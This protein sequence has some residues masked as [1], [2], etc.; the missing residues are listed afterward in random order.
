MYYA[1]FDDNCTL[2]LNFRHTI[3]FIIASLVSSIRLACDWRRSLE[4]EGHLGSQLTEAEAHSLAELK[5][6]YLRLGISRQ[7]MFSNQYM[8]TRPASRNLSRA[9]STTVYGQAGPYSRINTQA[10]QQ[11]PVNARILMTLNQMRKLFLGGGVAP[12]VQRGYSHSLTMPRKRSDGHSYQ[13]RFE[14]QSEYGGTDHSYAWDI[15]VTPSWIRQSRSA[16]ITYEPTKSRSTKTFSLSMTP[17]EKSFQQQVTQYAAR[18]PSPHYNQ[19]SSPSSNYFNAVQPKSNY[20]YNYPQYSATI[21]VQDPYPSTGNNPAGRVY[22]GNATRI[23]PARQYSSGASSA[24]AITPS[25]IYQSYSQH[26]SLSRGSGRVVQPLR[27]NVYNSDNA[28]TVFSPHRKTENSCD[29]NPSSPIYPAY[30]A[31]MD[32]SNHTDVQPL[33][34]RREQSVRPVTIYSTNNP[35]TKTTT[36]T[37]QV[38]KPIPAQNWSDTSRIMRSGTFITTTKKIP[39]GRRPDVNGELSGYQSSKW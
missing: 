8:G 38:W 34:Y 24:R 4:I 6:N 36:E 11:R 19:N 12:T 28:S 15:P 25:T 35:T 22:N 20:G 13:N 3:V 1:D 21:Q 30:P 2:Q 17:G 16:N 32:K 18:P 7:P 26:N 27:V 10:P 33:R 37:R 23:Y 29:W 5:S 31:H 39:G 9:A 14:T